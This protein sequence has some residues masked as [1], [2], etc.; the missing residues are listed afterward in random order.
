MAQV[1][2]VNF[3]DFNYKDII[4][5]IKSDGEDVSFNYAKSPLFPFEIN[6]QLTQTEYLDSNNNAVSNYEDGTYTLYFIRLNATKTVTNTSASYPDGTYNVVF[7]CDYANYEVEGYPLTQN[8]LTKCLN[9]V[10][11]FSVNSTALESVSAGDDEFVTDTNGSE[12]DGPIDYTYAE[13]LYLRT[14]ESL[15]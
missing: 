2:Y 15:L 4:L 9:L 13:N 7:S 10:K 1:F 5:K 6:S 8:Y 11:N 3:S 14:I 12:Y